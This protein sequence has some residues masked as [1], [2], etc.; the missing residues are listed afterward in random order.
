[1][2]VNIRNARLDDADELFELVKDFAD[3]LAAMPADHPRKRILR[4][5]EQAIRRDI[6]FIDRHPTTLFQPVLAMS[7][8]SAFGIV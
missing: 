4:L 7:T 8:S 3:A 1:M 5:L 6:H 2:D